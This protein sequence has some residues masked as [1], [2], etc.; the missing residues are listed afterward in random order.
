MSTTGELLNG[1]CIIDMV[2]EVLPGGVDGAT[3]SLTELGIRYIIL[4]RIYS[5]TF[6]C[7]LTFENEILL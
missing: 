6:L 2:E 4:V 5:L 7:F 1:G 3:H